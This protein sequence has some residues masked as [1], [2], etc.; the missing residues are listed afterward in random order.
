[1][2]KT[3]VGSCKSSSSWRR[4]AL[5]IVMIASATWRLTFRR[6]AIP[7]VLDNDEL[8]AKIDML[9]QEKADIQKALDM[10]DNE[11][12]GIIC[13]A[14][15]QEAELRKLKASHDILQYTY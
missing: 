7:L 10:K 13:N 14:H 5:S 12:F 8:R 2:P 1:L 15:V 9:E 3:N 6:H 11:N 4:R